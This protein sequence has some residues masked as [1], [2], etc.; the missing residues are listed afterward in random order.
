VLVVMEEE[1][2]LEVAQ[3]PVKRGV[4]VVHAGI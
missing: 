1:A 2:A 3:G 4:S